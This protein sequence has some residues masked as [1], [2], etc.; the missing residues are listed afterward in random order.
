MK[1]LYVTCNLHYISVHSFIHC[2][3]PVMCENWLS[4]ENTWI[5]TADKICSSGLSW[6]MVNKSCT[7]WP[8]CSFMFVIQFFLWPPASSSWS[9]MNLV[10]ILHTNSLVPYSQSRAASPGTCSQMLGV[11]VSNP[12]SRNITVRDYLYN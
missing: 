6:V 3:A 5:D 7:R 4:R 9:P 12:Y 10:T 8:V 11:Q 2:L 1:I